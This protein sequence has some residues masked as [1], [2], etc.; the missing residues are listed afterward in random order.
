MASSVRG[1][2]HQLYVY[3]LFTLICENMNELN[4]NIDSEF[5][6]N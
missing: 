5:K 3:N 4:V 6:L 1:R 2:G